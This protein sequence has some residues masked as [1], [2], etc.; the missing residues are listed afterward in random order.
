MSAKTSFPKSEIKI[1]LLE[2]VHSSGQKIL[3][4]EGFHVE[5]HTKAFS[6]S[7]LIDRAAD[8]HIVGIRS[9]TKITAAYLEKAPR[10]LGI[11]CFCIGTNQ[12]DLNTAM[13]RG[14]PVFNAPFS[15]TRSVAEMIIAEIIMLARRLGDQTRHLHSGSWKK[16][17]KGCY[18]VRGKTLGIVGYGNI[19]SQV[20]VLAESLGMKVIFYDV[21]TKMPLGNSRAAT[22][23]EGL[24]KESDFVSFHVPETE[25]TKN[26]IGEKQLKAMKPGSFLL[27]AS[28][29]TVIQIG[30][31]AE[32]LRSGK[33]AGAAID[34]YP[35]E[36]EANE[37]EFK[38]ELQNLPNVILTA[39]VGGSTEEAQYNIGIEVAQF[40]L[41]YINRG[42]T[43]RSVNFPQLDIPSLPETHRILNIHRNVPGVLRDINSIVSGLGANIQA[44]ALSTNS[45]IGYLVMDVDQ[46]LSDQVKQK[47][48]E[49][50]TSIKTRILY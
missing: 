22:S 27:N 4:A 13:K 1:L 49:L 36:P 32:A 37:A 19:G 44:Q 31:L 35:E 20:S 26:M 29:G 33:L 2:G 28:R 30:A 48:S 40:L 47:I 3:E 18:E 50:S 38:S 24:L 23:L 5:T 6:E 10:L 43:A 17:A 12:V 39:H 14:V 25:H 34:V 42:T 46:Q 15:N 45:E 21:V 41:Q 8:A 7:E 9:K 16:S 11:G